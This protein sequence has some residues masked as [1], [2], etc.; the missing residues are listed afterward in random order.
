MHVPVFG[1]FSSNFLVIGSV[2]KIINQIENIKIML[3]ICRKAAE[4]VEKA[5]KPLVGRK[6]AGEV[7]IGHAGSRVKKIDKVAEDATLDVLMQTGLSMKVLSEETGTISIGEKPK[8]ICVIDPLDGS[9]NAIHNIPIYSF[10]IA[11]AEY[12]PEANL[13]DINYALVKNLVTG[14]IFEARKRKGCTLDGKNISTPKGE[15]KGSTMCIYV[16]DN[17]KI[18]NILKMPKRIRTLGSIA[19]ELCY[20]AKGD[21]HAVVDLRNFL[22]TTDIAAGKLIV[23]EAGGVVTD[24]NG[25]PIR[26]SVLK[27]EKTCLIASGNAKINKEIVNALR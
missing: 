21:Y 18:L 25:L 4:K 6:S 13:D 11:F 22:R 10:S 8:L 24:E 16:Q 5:V 12:R 17:P 9:Y 27:I 2:I 3:N 15:L 20:L 1:R 19:L 14:E 26:K 23:E 7:V